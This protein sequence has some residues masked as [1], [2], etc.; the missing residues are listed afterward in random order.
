MK[1][2]EDGEKEEEIKEQDKGERNKKRNVRKRKSSLVGS[3]SKLWILKRCYIN[4]H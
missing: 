1:Q 4:F 2:K 3:V